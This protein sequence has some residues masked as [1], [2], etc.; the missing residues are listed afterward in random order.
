[1]YRRYADTDQIQRIR[2]DA[3]GGR[4]QSWGQVYR[5]MP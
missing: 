2:R 4:S 5:R 1:L 3:S